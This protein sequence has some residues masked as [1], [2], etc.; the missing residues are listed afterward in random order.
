MVGWIILGALMCLIMAVLFLRVKLRISFGGALCVIA[1]IGPVTLKIIPPPERKK[2]TPAKEPASAGKKM[3]KKG[4]KAAKPQLSF[5]DVREGLSA[6]WRALQRALHRAGRR[7]C[8]DPL[9]LNCVFGSENPVNTAQWYGWASAAMWTVMPRLEQMVRVPD[10]HIHLGMDFDAAENRI[11]GQVGVRCRIV[12][13]L[14]IGF[15][16]AGPLLRFAVPFLKKRKKA[17]GAAQTECV[18]EKQE[19]HTAHEAA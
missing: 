15:A 1:S 13:L 5:A 2:E 3:R 19:E 4:A 17:G 11:S 6:V 10:P 8:F 18:S 9:E 14:S 12:D 7:I 16:A